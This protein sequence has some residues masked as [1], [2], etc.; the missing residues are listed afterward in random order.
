MTPEIIIGVLI[1]LVLTAYGFIFSSIMSR[2]S[3]LEDRVI[4]NPDKCIKRFE[5][6][7]ETQKEMNPIWAEIRE[8]LAGIEA[9]LKYLTN[10]K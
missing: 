4:C 10:N 2:I 1:G 8:R 7:E 5:M 3:K 9:T 6:I